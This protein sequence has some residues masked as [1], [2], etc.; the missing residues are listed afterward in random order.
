MV[1]PNNYETWN[2]T[3]GTISY[4][5]RNIV[6]VPY[7]NLILCDFEKLDDAIHPVRQF[8]VQEVREHPEDCEKSRA[9]FQIDEVSLVGEMIDL[10]CLI[11]V[12]LKAKLSENN[13]WH[14]VSKEKVWGDALNR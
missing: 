6:D 1:K 5:G 2:Y 13:F 11:N 10:R 12:S 8:S 7:W 14:L 4:M 3:P 9:V